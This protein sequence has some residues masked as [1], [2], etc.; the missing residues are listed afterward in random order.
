M[1]LLDLPKELLD[2]I[3][4]QALRPDSF[5]SLLLSC[6]AIY[7][8]CKEH[9]PRYN[10]LLK[11]RRMTLDGDTQPSNNGVSAV[12]EI[13]LAIVEDPEIADFIEVLDLRKAQMW[14]SQ[15]TTPVDKIDAL[16]K[17][18]RS[19]PYLSIAGQDPHDWV[20]M[21]DL[22]VGHILDEC[23]VVCHQTTL[24]LTLLP[25]LKDLTL[26]EHWGRVSDE[27]GCLAVLNAVVRNARD[28]LSPEDMQKF[29]ADSSDVALLSTLREKP[30]SSLEQLRPYEEVEY[31][32]ASR[33]GLVDVAPFMILPN[34]KHLHVSNLIGVSDGY[35]G[36]PFEWPYDTAESGLQGAFSNL[37]SIHLEGCVVDHN[38]ITE[39]VSHTPRLQSLR[40]SHHTKWHG[41]AHDW[42]AGAFVNALAKYAGQTLRSLS[43]NLDVLYGDTESAISTLHN[44]EVLENFEADVWTFFC[45]SEDQEMN[46]TK[47]LAEL[48]P[49]SIR[50]VKLVFN[51][52]NDNRDFEDLEVFKSLCGPRSAYGAYSDLQQLA[53]CAVE[54]SQ[55]PLFELQNLADGLEWSYKEVPREGVVGKMPRA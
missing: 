44:F 24:L 50:S 49:N 31:D 26:P 7:A 46:R 37:E 27:E 11:W 5:E 51:E 21:L 23:S 39:L 22:D 30:L 10:A 13:L 4:V 3:A 14:K 28:A 8:S 20:K 15:R 33:G 29:E 38:G 41:C 25:K 36:I 53:I 16:R 47:S 40:Y 17:L 19:S 55:L 54:T 52:P 48:L 12:T 1:P 2:N 42:D 18:V 9:I 45:T 6:K 32:P 35:T 34:I 43:L